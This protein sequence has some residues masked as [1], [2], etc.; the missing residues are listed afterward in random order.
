[1]IAKIHGDRFIS[2]RETAIAPASFV[3]KIDVPVFIAGS[4][5]DEET[6]SHFA[7][8]LGDFAPNIPLQVTLMNGTHT[9]S[10][11]PA[12]LGTMVRVPRLLRR[13]DD[14]DD[15]ARDPRDRVRG[16]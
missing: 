9:D 6:G 8:M 7:D 12:V 1:M 16:C 3:H 13:P 15:P 2:P 10:I 5:Q 14:P 4:W 11:D